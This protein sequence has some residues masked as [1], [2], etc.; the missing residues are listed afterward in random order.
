MSPTSCPDSSTLAT[1]VPPGP[2]VEQRRFQETGRH[3]ADHRHRR[4]VRRQARTAD[5][6]VAARALP[7]RRRDL[8]GH[9]VVDRGFVELVGAVAPAA[10]RPAASART[11]GRRRARRSARLPAARRTA[12]RRQSSACPAPACPQPEQRS[13][14]ASPPRRRRVRSAPQSK[15]HGSGICSV[16]ERSRATA[17][18][19]STSGQTQPTSPLTRLPAARSCSPASATASA[20]SLGSEYHCGADQPNCCAYSTASALEAL[21]LR[22]WRGTGRTA[23]ARSRRAARAR[24]RR[25]SAATA[26]ARM[27]RSRRWRRRSRPRRVRGRA[28]PR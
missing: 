21:L 24:R 4:R 28:R 22:R 9:A 10:A 2:S 5:A 12:G 20:T 17:S 11:R 19:S 14:A 7:R 25:R 3:L 23:P 1:W 15:T 16:C 18:M 13:T 27:G 6:H 8:V 26:P